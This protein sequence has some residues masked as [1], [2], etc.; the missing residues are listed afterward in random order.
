MDLFFCFFSATGAAPSEYPS[1]N[2]ETIRSK[3][4]AGNERLRE[5]T[6]R[7]QNPPSCRCMMPSQNPPQRRHGAGHRR[8]CLQEV[9]SNAGRGAGLFAWV[10]S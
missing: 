2:D 10:A 8:V 4:A 3:A 9:I 1:R 7:S 6:A 5:D